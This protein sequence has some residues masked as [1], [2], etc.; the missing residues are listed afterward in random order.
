MVTT[1]NYIYEIGLL[2]WGLMIIIE[3]LNRHNHI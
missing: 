1:V 2:L 3:A